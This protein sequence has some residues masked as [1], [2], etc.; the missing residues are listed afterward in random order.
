MNTTGDVPVTVTLTSDVKPQWLNVI[1]RLQS[2]CHGNQGLAVLSIRVLV[3]AAGEPLLW[4][5]PVRTNLE[6]K[7]RALDTLLLLADQT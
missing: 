7:S 3:D 2:A 6:P 5:Q 4:T 1:R